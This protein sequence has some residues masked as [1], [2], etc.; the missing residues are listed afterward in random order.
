MLT[1]ARRN[2]PLADFLKADMR[3]FHLLRPKQCCMITGRSISY[4]VTDEDVYNAF[5]AI[6]RNLTKPGLL[7]FDFID[8]SKFLPSIKNGKTVTHQAPVKDKIYRR[9]S[10]WKINAL[11]KGAFDWGSVFYEEVNG[12]LTKLGE[13]QS[14]IRA[15]WIEEMKSFLKTSG[16]KVEETIPRPSYAFDTI[17]IVASKI[18][19]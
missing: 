7:C 14:T 17:V 12:T 3:N 5:R 16:F 15:F 19:V 6:Y 18:I 1:M 2:N 4:L 11:Q 10:S 8:A 9:K 13:D